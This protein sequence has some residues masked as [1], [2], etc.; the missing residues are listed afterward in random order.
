MPPM[1]LSHQLSLLFSRDQGSAGTGARPGRGSAWLHLLTI[2]D[3][4]S[5]CL[6][7]P[8]SGCDRPV[9]GSGRWGTERSSSVPSPTPGCPCP[10]LHPT[11]DLVT[12]G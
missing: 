10:S 7:E 4:A 8:S 6:M 12:D 9:G 3:P 5:C 11:H 2:P 1:N